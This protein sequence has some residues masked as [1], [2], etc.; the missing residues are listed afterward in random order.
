MIR[1][2]EFDR[3]HNFRDVG[4]YVTA[5]G[6]RVRWRRL[7]RSDSLGALTGADAERFLRLGIRTV[8]DLRH[9]DEAEAQGR[10]PGR[11][12]YRYHNL[13]VEQQ[14]WDR[15]AYDPRAGLGRFF[16][17]HYRRVAEM[18]TAELADALRLIADADN[19]PVVV[20][21]AAGKDRT[22]VVTALVLALLGVPHEDV[23]ADYA[24]TDLA[25][26][27]F[28]R[29]W[30]ARHPGEEIPWAGFGRAPAEAMRLF[31]T[32]LCAAHGSVRS[33]CRNALGIGDDLVE[34]LRDHLLEDLGDGDR[35]R[36]LERSSPHA[37]T[38]GRLG[39]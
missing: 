33:Y 12:G 25:A 23:I 36:S 2:I 18:G 28:A 10:V 26:E 1:H 16:A 38:D 34:R 31:L 11:D 7:Y 17:D 37:A 13:S 15:A 14:P 4:G 35:D 39:E 24:L 3:L 5:D 30:L 27:K 9:P 6:R 20:H 8:I 32:E 19:A 22:G 21:C 29:D